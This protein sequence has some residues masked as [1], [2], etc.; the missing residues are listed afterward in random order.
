MTTTAQV[1]EWSGISAP[2]VPDK[3][4]EWVLILNAEEYPLLED[5]KEL[6]RDTLESLEID[7]DEVEL[8]NFAATRIGLPKT[9]ARREDLP[10]S[11]IPTVRGKPVWWRIRFPWRRES[12]SVNWPALRKGFGF[13]PMITDPTEADILLDSVGGNLEQAPEPPPDF[14][15]RIGEGAGSVGQEIKSLGETVLAVSALAGGAYILF[16]IMKKRG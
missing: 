13:M 1:N 7:S 9:R 4:Q 14:L 11:F 15:E 5:Q 2:I 10:I 3:L 12:D 6:I 16:N 8:I